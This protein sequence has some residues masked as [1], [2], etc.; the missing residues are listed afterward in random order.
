M[1]EEELFLGFTS[2]QQETYYTKATDKCVQ[3]LAERLL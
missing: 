3:L 2:R 1:I